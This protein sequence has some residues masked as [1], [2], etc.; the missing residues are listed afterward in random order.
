MAQA[1]YREAG[2]LLL[3]P[4]RLIVG[5]D[6]QEVAGVDAFLAS[7]VI[8]LVRVFPSFV[9]SILVVLVSLGFST[10]LL[11]VRLRAWLG[12]GTTLDSHSGYRSSSATS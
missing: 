12:R 3:P 9:R 8:N 1:N 2:C 10:P 11:A 6:K 7:H 4:F 5:R